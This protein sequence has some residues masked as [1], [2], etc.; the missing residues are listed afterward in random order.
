MRLKLKSKPQ[1]HI[2]QKSES[3]P[4]SVFN[5]LVREAIQVTERLNA[6]TTVDGQRLS[7]A[8]L[9]RETRE[10][11]RISSTQIA[12]LREVM[13]AATPGFDHTRATLRRMKTFLRGPNW[14]GAP[15]D[16][17]KLR[18]LTTDA[19]NGELARI[20]SSPLELF[21]VA[22]QMA[23]EEY[24]ESFGLAESSTGVADEVSSLRERQKTLFDQIGTAYTADDLHVE[25]LDARGQAT[26]SFKLSDGKVSIAPP[27]DAGRR[28]VDY[29][30]SH[31]EKRS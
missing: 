25:S 28:L 20:N 15:K 10:M 22:V 4:I 19:S 6:L 31:A 26:T 24:P 16:A 13:A 9:E 5:A 17:S 12:K 29:L 23:S 14:S 8:A 27:N 21:C 18:F 3:A 1:F 2:K 11:A 7:A 30:I